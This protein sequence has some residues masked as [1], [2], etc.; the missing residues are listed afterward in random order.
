MNLPA[1][2]DFTGP[3]AR[4]ERALREMESNHQSPEA[5]QKVYLQ[6]ADLLAQPPER[7]EPG[8][9]ILVFLLGTEKYAVPLA[10]VSEVIARPPVAPAPGAPSE[11]DGLIQVRGEIRVV[12]N[13]GKLLG[14]ASESEA[15]K[16]SIAL[17][18][19]A[20]GGEAA[21]LVDQVEDIR[22]VRPQERRPAPVGSVQSAWMTD[23]LVIVLDPVALWR[24]ESKTEY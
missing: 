14:L 24:A 22:N 11:I 16:P 13:L 17:L 10:G 4:V 15:V 7:N 5:I 12:W 3:K 6:R 1:G 21:V 20:Q 9:N 18:L 23:D 19:R 2:L 8:E